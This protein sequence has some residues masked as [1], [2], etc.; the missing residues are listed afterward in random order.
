[1]KNNCKFLRLIATKCEDLW[2]LTSLDPLLLPFLVK[3]CP[4]EELP[5]VFT[6]LP[7]YLSAA[8]LLELIGSDR[9]HGRYPKPLVLNQVCRIII[10]AFILLGFNNVLMQLSHYPVLIKSLTDSIKAS[11][12][13]RYVL[14][15]IMCGVTGLNPRNCVVIHIHTCT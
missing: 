11:S 6:I 4:P 12:F 14:Y 9:G 3:I 7:P 2:P 8:Y 5:D 13:L 1:M 15:I 10:C